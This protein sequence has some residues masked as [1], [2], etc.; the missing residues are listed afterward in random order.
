MNDVF[1]MAGM[2]WKLWFALVGG[3]LFWNMIASWGLG[4][5]F[6]VSTGMTEC[7]SIRWGHTMGAFLFLLWAFLRPWPFDALSPYFTFW[8]P[9]AGLNTG[10]L[11]DF[12]VLFGVSMIWIVF[13]VWLIGNPER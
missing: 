7:K 9:G 13:F 1:P 6:A 4:M 5:L 12:G 3:W 11:C 8:S 10:A 2:E